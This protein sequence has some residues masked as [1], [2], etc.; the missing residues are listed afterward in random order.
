MFT[1]TEKA[2]R[3]QPFFYENSFS[4]ILPQFLHLIEGN[5]SKKHFLTFC[6]IR[7]EVPN[8][9]SNLL[10]VVLFVYMYMPVTSLSGFH[11]RGISFSTSS[12]LAYGSP[13]S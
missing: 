9:V 10:V 6:D 2:T 8:F 11:L 12:C 13:N 1:K 7:G 4:V 3:S 5:Y